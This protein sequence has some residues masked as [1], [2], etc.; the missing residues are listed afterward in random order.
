MN[1][2]RSSLQRSAIAASRRLASTAAP[3]KPFVPN[4]YK[5]NFKKDYLSDPSTYPILIIMGSALTFMVGVGFRNL[6][7][8]K[9]LRI[10]PEN[11]HE[12]LQSWGEEHRDTMTNAFANKP[13]ALNSQR[14]AQIRS[15]KGLGVE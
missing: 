4:I 13:I 14:W 5:A 8:Y 11:K 3:T 15:G 6:G 1:A 7:Y 12:I 10:R 2:L 9:D